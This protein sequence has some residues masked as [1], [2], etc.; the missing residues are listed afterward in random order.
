MRRNASHFPNCNYETRPPASPCALSL[1]HP[2]HQMCQSRNPR[3]SS[4]YHTTPHHTSEQNRQRR[5]D[6]GQRRYPSSQLPTPKS[7]ISNS[8]ILLI[9]RRSSTA[10]PPAVYQQRAG[11]QPPFRQGP[12]EKKRSEHTKHLHTAHVAGCLKQRSRCRRRKFGWDGLGG[13]CFVDLLL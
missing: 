9:M 1:H 7:Q 8:Q 11:P 5:T 10:R 4:P 13:I 12:S 6:H 2:I 3:G